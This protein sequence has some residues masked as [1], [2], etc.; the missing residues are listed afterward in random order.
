MHYLKVGLSALENVEASLDRL[1]GTG[2]P[3]TIMDFPTGYGRVT[4]FLRAGFPSATV[5]GSDLRS[6]AVAFCGREFGIRGFASHTDFSRITAPPS[7]DIIWC[8]S[9][10]THID[11]EAAT[12]L[13]RFFYQ[14]LRPGGLCLVS[15][16]GKRT[17]DSLQCGESQ[18]RLTAA[19]AAEV[20]RGYR[21]CGYGFS[22]YPGRS[23]Y[24]ISLTEPECLSRIAKEAGDW[25]LLEHRPMGWDNHQDV[26]ALQRTI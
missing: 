24:G 2:P 20:L 19:G 16:H 12:R 4:R 5:L 9:L 25:D 10:L 17:I 7:I 8:G 13:L 22:S 21:E 1:Q 26:Y 23:G 14:S 3:A 15:A 6:G 11:R 18:Y